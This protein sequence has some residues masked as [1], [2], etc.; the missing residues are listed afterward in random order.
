[1]LGFP[2][3]VEGLFFFLEAIFAGIY[4]WGWRWGGVPIAVSGIFGAMSVIVV[5]SWM[6]QPG[7]FTQSGGRITS[8]NP[9]QVFF[10]HAAVYEM[11]HMILAAYMVAG[12]SWPGCT[13]RASCAAGATAT[14]TRGS[15]SGS[16]PPRP[17]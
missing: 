4:L 2:F 15:R 7:G 13:R 3:G 1:V 5:N 12:S 16:C 6:N 8:V 14:T 17:G 11:P 10:N 9:W